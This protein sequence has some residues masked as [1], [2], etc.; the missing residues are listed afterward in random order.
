MEERSIPRKGEC[1][2]HFKGECYQILAIAVH[3]ETKERLVVYEGLCKAHKVYAEPLTLFVSKVDKEQYPDAVQSYRFEPVEQAQTEEEPE[4]VGIQQFLDLD[5]KEAKVE[6]LQKHRL[7]ITDSFLS[8]VAMSMDFVESK[9]TL[10]ER[11]C[12]LQQ[13]LRTLIRYESG[14]RV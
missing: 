13:Y 2:R 5:S 4:K 10:D 9:E 7:L 11:Y 8:S 3:S 14:R 6:Y 1:Y 12:D